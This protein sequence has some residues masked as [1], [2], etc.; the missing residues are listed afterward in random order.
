MVAADLLQAGHYYV[1]YFCTTYSGL[2]VC[3]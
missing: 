3:F 2:T 1:Q